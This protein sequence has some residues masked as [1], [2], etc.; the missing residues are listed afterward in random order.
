MLDWWL[1]LAPVYRGPTCGL[2]Q[3]GT[4]D[5]TMVPQVPRW[6]QCHRLKG[7]GADA[8]RQINAGRF[9]R[10]QGLQTYRIGTTANQRVRA[11]ARAQGKTGTRAGII[12]G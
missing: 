1:L 3:T 12:A 9:A 4:Y 7:E 5:L 2:G 8:G 11:E 10:G 6:C